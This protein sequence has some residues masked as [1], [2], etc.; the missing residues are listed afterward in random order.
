MLP[1]PTVSVVIPAHRLDAWLDLAV[2]SA[3]A[4]KDVDIEVLVVLDGMAASEPRWDDPRVRVLHRPTQGGP[5]AAMQQGVDAARGRYV[6]RLDSDDL[7][8]P[9][10]FAVQVAYLDTHPD[11]V[12]VSALVRLVD[13]EDRVTG[14]VAA[15]T[16][17]DI[18]RG[19]LL[20]NFVAHS[21]LVFRSESGVAAGGYDPALR[22]MEDYDF[23]L[24][25]AALGPIAQLDAH[26][27]GYRLHAGQV[28][29][30][31]P[32]RG[33][34][35]DAVLRARRGLARVLGVGPVT[36]WASD[37]AW[38]AV[39]RWRQLTARTQIAR[40]RSVT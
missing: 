34:H 39:R 31:I 20:Y 4:S 12:A 23:I 8:D 30:S 15:R 21:T 9:R 11:A 36:T 5:S 33:P 17:D 7:C 10:R 37:T 35:I 14:E 26:L 38:G 16:G 24:R 19:L 1:D 22:V 40:V 18:R 6:A 29:R 3:L 27:V 32:V 2:A 28:S 25:L 13:E